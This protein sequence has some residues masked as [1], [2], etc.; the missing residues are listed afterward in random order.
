MKK[1]VNKR[2]QIKTEDL[3]LILSN[4]SASMKKYLPLLIIAL[5]LLIGSVVIAVL[6]PDQL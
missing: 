2:E 1:K 5:F 3:K 6:A 4:I